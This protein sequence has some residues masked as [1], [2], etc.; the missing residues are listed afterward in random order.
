M[1]S[2][3]LSWFY[4]WKWLHYDGGDDVVYCHLRVT[5]LI[6][7]TV[8][9]KRRE[10]ALVVKEFCNAIAAFRKHEGSDC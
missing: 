8:K 4:K 6:R 10:A 2:S 9:W 5:A 1:H 7:K 3:Q